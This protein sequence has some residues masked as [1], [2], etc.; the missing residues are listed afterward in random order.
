[1]KQK[2][3][4]EGGARNGEQPHQNYV[5]RL[6][7]FKNSEMR[8]TSGI[9]SGVLSWMHVCWYFRLEEPTFIILK[10]CWGSG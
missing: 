3:S 5:V 2:S 6:Q 10:K 4:N 7:Q 1:M 9:E 8:Q